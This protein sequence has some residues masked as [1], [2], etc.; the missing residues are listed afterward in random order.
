MSQRNQQLLFED[1]IAEMHLEGITIEGIA[2]ELQIADTEVTNILI[3]LFSVNPIYR[4][5]IDDK[6]I[7][8]QFNLKTFGSTNI[9]EEYVN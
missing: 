3:K 5:L 1:K 4:V 9:G 8:K 6:I 7:T 2:N